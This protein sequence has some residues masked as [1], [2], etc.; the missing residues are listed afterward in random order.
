MLSDDELHDEL[1]PSWMRLAECAGH[2]D[3]VLWDDRA[4]LYDGLP[5]T[6]ELR[7]RSAAAYCAVCPVIVE[8]A[9]YAERNGETGV[10]GGR[11]RHATGRHRVRDL[12]RRPVAGA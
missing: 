3:P 6:R 10:W 12:L 9:E 1:L 11:V 2:P 8:C 4:E 5:A 7:Y